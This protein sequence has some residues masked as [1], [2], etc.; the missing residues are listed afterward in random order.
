VA[1]A[2]TKPLTG[3]LFETHKLAMIG[4]TA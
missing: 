1:D 4:G 3:A 2:L